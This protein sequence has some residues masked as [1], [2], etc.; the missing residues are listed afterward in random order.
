MS[1]EDGGLYAYSVSTWTYNI[2]CSMVGQYWKLSFAIIA[3]SWLAI[4][5]IFIDTVYNSK[6]RLI[7]KRWQFWSE[8]WE[9]T[10]QN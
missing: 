8:F 1:L 10:A 6:N 7:F 3:L 9:H 4:L 2:I 5:Q